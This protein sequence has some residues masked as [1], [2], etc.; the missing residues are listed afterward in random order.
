MLI[1]IFII[2]VSAVILFHELGHFLFAKRA[3]AW[4]QEFGL[5]LPPRIFGKQF[6]ETLYSV[7][8]LPIGAFVKVLGESGEDDDEINDSN[9]HLAITSKSWW[10]RTKFVLGG[11]FFNFILA[12]F[13]LLVSQFVGNV[14][15]SFGDEKNVSDIVVVDSYSKI[16][17]LKVEIPENFD[18]EKIP[19]KFLLTKQ[20]ENLKNFYGKDA[21]FNFSKISTFDEAEKIFDE[22]NLKY[23]RK[24]LET[25]SSLSKIPKT[26]KIKKISLNKKNL[27][28]SDQ[29]DIEKIFL[30]YA[31][32][33]LEISYETKENKIFTKTIT[34]N[35]G[36]FYLNSGL[37]TLN[38][39]E[40]RELNP[41]L[42]I[43][44]VLK[45]FLNGILQVV[46][47]IFY[48][49]SSLFKSGKVPNE[50][51]SVVGIYPQFEAFFYFG[52]WKFVLLS[53]PALLSLNLAVANL[54]PIPALD[55]GH[56]FFLLI[57]KIR[58]GKKLNQKTQNIINFAGFGILI[59]FLIFLVG[60]DLSKII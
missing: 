3:G 44:N 22:L 26:I 40:E 50:I 32:I 57:E 5:G 54:L 41:F 52:G 30:D 15:L 12:F 33:P 20:K 39:F 43:W 14:Q 58:G 25:P 42:A 29:G 23:T 16:L 60:R 21:I 13:L 45:S 35:F 8:L 9:R 1:L 48:I 49:F 36:D 46:F 11:I 2:I 19:E 17:S 27:K 38:I 7:N 31:G 53:F 10:H 28:F 55:G 24:S 6:G 37:L 34:T 18:V 56:F 47:G 51:S 4:V 59:F